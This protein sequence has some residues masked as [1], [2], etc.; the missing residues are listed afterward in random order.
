M[1]VVHLTQEECKAIHD[2]IGM[3]SGH[4]PEYA[5]AWD[6]TDS[7]DD[8]QVSACVKIYKAAGESVPKGL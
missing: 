3:L 2:L 6:G 4:N 7:L 5:F 8:P 1:E